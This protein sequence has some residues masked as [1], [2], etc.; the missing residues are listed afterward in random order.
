MAQDGAG[1]ISGSRD[2]RRDIFFGVR[3]RKSLYSLHAHSTQSQ[4][5]PD[6]F[7][8][9]LQGIEAEARSDIWPFILGD[10]T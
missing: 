2:L 3:N 9:L 1:R 7:I 6:S 4:R 10:S 5:R 8:T